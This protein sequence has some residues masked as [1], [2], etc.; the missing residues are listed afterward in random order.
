[1]L[2]S[3]KTRSK[4]EVWLFGE[5]VDKIKTTKLPSNGDILRPLLFLTKCKKSVKGA[6]NI[7]YSGIYKI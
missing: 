4:T 6:C 1:M 2:S 7:V 3:I 5:T